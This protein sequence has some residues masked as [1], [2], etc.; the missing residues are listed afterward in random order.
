MIFKDPSVPGVE[1]GLKEV[2]QSADLEN[3]LDMV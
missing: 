2:I 1:S 3:S